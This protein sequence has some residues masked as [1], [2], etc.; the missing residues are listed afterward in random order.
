[1][2]A[3]AVVAPHMFVEN[4]LRFEWAGRYNSPLLCV[5]QSLPGLKLND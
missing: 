1:M 3:T 5:G 2:G 4:G